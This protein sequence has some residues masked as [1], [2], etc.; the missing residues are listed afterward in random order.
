MGCHSVKLMKFKDET[1][2][3]LKTEK[4][5][6]GTYKAYTLGFSG[7]AIVGISLAQDRA[8]IA[9]EA[10]KAPSAVDEHVKSET[11]AIPRVNFILIISLLTV[12]VIAFL[13]YLKKK[14]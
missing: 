3:D 1:W 13:L 2:I 12:I 7:F 8:P 5:S 11:T 14:R 9:A 10:A 4:I 6:P